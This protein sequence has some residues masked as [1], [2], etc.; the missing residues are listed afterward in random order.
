VSAQAP[1]ARPPSGPAATDVPGAVTRVVGDVAATA[2]GGTKQAAAEAGRA[3]AGATREAAQAAHAGALPRRVALARGR[4]A[5]AV[6]ILGVLG[7]AGIFAAVRARRSEAIDLALMLRL[8]RRRRPWLD[9]LM[10][11]G[12]WPGFP[13]QSRVIPPAVIGTLWVLRFRTEAAFALAGWGTGALSTVLK[14]A[15]DRPRPI[16]GTNTDLR[17]VIAPLGGSSFP[18]GHVITFV[19][20]YGFL[21]YLS[22]TLSRDAAMRRVTTGSLLGLVLVVGPSRIYQGHHWPTDVTASYLLGTSYLIVVVAGYRRFKGAE[23]GVLGA[24]ADRALPATTL[25]GR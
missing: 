6:A 19:G 11:I 23:A 7:F 15:M 10:T 17:V 12:S 2:V 18:S 1:S 24:V 20:T 14:E 8:Q 21:A 9:R 22:H 5:T 25:A 4:G 16:A 3:V 13:P